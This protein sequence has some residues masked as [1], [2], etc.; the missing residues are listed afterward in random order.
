MPVA[1]WR[2]SYQ[3]IRQRLRSAAS[4]P[5]LY[6]CTTYDG[7]PS[8]RENASQQSPL[9]PPSTDKITHSSCRPCCPSRLLRQSVKNFLLLPTSN[10][11]PNEDITHSRF[12]ATCFPTRPTANAIKRRRARGTRETL[13]KQPCTLEEVAVPDAFGMYPLSLS[14]NLPL[15]SSGL[16]DM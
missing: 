4:F 7:G 5:L 14:D 9:Q 2:S 6:S 11:A 1:S 16:C 13:A 10:F 15:Y 12:T 8:S 3:Q